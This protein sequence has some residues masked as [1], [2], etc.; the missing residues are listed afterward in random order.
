MRTYRGHA[1]SVS[2]VAWSA[3][4]TVI[5][6]GSLDTTVQLWDAATGQT[7]RVYRGHRAPVADLA[8]SPDATL[9]ASGD[10][11]GDIHVWRSS[12]GQ[13]QATYHGHAH[14]IR[15]L[16]WSPNG[17][18]VA[19]G[20]I[21]GQIRLWQPST[22]D[23]NITTVLSRTGHGTIN[24]LAFSPDSSTVASCEG[25]Q[26]VYLWNQS[27]PAVLTYRGHTHETL[28]VCWSPNGS[29]LASVD[30]NGTSIGGT[31]QLW[32]AVTGT[33]QQSTPQ[34]E[35]TQ[36]FRDVAWSPNGSRLVTGCQW[37]PLMTV[38]STT[39]TPELVA[40]GHT[41]AINRVAWSPD[42]QMIATAGTDATVCLWRAPGAL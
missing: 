3:N 10:D 30:L 25:D 19:S 6:S 13:L 36:S 35:S 34:P 23:L 40:L 18:L 4:G 37:S 29:H 21:S 5:A 26:M 42:S 7:L 16:S 9:V 2:G 22:Q 38:W 14:S 8:W 27:N 28:G 20:D 24:R 15:S 11:S 33:R 41:G 12:T 39:F 17:Q 31:L 32:D 1:S